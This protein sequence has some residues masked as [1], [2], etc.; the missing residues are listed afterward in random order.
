MSNPGIDYGLGRTNINMETGIRYGIISQ[1]SVLQAWA[2][3]SEPDYGQ[4]TCPK[5]GS[6]AIACDAI[7]AQDNE[8][9]ESGRGCA[10]WQCD[11]CQYVFDACEAFGDEAQS[12]NYSGNGYE[13]HSCFD[14][15]EIFVTASPF[16][17]LAPYCSPCAPGAG[18]LDSANDDGVK[19]YCLGHDWFD[20]NKAPYAV[21]SVATG[22]LVQP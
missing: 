9:Y 15:C 22:E 12:Y 21:Y 16:Y 14:N 3:S 8:E 13:L 4:A 18:N 5:C 6:D 20:D 10:D 11:S 1:N 2:D 7:T 19:T 17:T